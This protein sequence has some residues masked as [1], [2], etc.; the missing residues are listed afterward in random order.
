MGCGRKQTSLKWSAKRRP[1]MQQRGEQRTPPV[2]NQ[3]RVSEWVRVLFCCCGDKCEAHLDRMHARHA[4]RLQSFL[5]FSSVFS[6]FYTRLSRS[7]YRACSLSFI[8]P[9]T[10]FCSLSILFCRWAVCFFWETEKK[11]LDFLFC[12]I[13]LLVAIVKRVSFFRFRDKK[14]W[15][16]REEEVFWV[17]TCGSGFFRLPLDHIRPQGSHSSWWARVLRSFLCNCQ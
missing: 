5:Q 11:A 3:L 1:K 13:F 16:E 17:F 10:I 2:W 4:P 6:L 8:D 12:W 7:T 15:L 9:E 14:R